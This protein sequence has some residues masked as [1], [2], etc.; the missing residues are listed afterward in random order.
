MKTEAR[1]LTCY[2]QD[3]R[4]L[5]KDLS[6]GPTKLTQWLCKVLHMELGHIKTSL[7]SMG[8]LAKEK[9]LRGEQLADMKQQL[10]KS[11]QIQLDEYSM[12]SKHRDCFHRD[13]VS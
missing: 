6:Q 7:G 4:T 13:N 10:N 11:L 2:C 1:A 12:Q 5:E 9:T 3:E 8:E